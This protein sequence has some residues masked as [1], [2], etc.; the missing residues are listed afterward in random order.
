V[1]DSSLRQGDACQRTE[2]EMQ[3][4]VY[5]WKEQYIWC[6]FMIWSFPSPP[7]QIIEECNTQ[8]G[9]MRQ[10]EELYH[11]SQTLE[12]YKLKVQNTHTHTHTHTHRKHVHAFYLSVF[13][14]DF[15]FEKIPHRVPPRAR[16]S[17]RPSR[18]SPRRDTWRR[19]GS[20]RKCPKEGLSSTRGQ[21][22]TPSTSS[23]SM[24]C[25]SSRPRKGES[26]ADPFLNGNEK[27][28]RLKERRV[29]PQTPQRLF[30]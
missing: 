3:Q 9:K 28:Y 12:F 14:F 1:R 10:M 11:I 20:C 19:K 7:R 8:V 15:Y 23:S 18:S 13:V 4:G 16:V 30:D 2:P 17:S 22:S 6:Y 24:I 27:R 29:S 26:T 25:S 5:V 21:S